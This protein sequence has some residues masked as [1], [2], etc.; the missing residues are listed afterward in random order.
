MNGIDVA[1]ESSKV[2]IAGLVVSEVSP[3]YHHW[4]ATKSLP[5]WLCEHGVPAMSGVDT[6]AVTKR[7]REDGSMLGKILSGE[8]DI[9]F[10]DPN[11]QNLASLVS[12]RE[13]VLYPAGKKRVVVVDCG[14]KNSIIRNLIDRDVTVLKVP[15]DYDFHQEEFDGVLVS[16][17]PG[18][19]KM[20]HPT[21]GQVFHHVTKPRLCR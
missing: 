19:P 2:Q 21:I 5:E 7:L 18:D 8:D 11:K 1:F 4:N 6:R 12:V 20:C 13:P 15:W 14:C 3:G 17:G 9:Q 10:Y 16:N